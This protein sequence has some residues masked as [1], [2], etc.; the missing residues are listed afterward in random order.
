MA[1]RRQDKG[2]PKGVAQRRGS[3]WTVTSLLPAEADVAK[4]MEENF[5]NNKNKKASGREQR[6]THNHNF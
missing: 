1:A 2:P 6:I 3:T 5:D 4:E